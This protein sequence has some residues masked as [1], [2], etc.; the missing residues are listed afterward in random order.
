MK[1]YEITERETIIRKFI[2]EAESED[3]Y[4]AGNFNFINEV[5]SD[6]IDSQIMNLEQIRIMEDET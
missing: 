1:T 6:C 5:D 4:Y 2:I 3:D